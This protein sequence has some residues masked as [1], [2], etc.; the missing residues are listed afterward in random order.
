MNYREYLIIE[1]RYNLFANHYRFYQYSKD[2]Q[3]KLKNFFYILIRNRYYLGEP[4]IGKY[5]GITVPSIIDIL[6]L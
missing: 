2:D 1:N 4:I 5:S 6:N 3:K